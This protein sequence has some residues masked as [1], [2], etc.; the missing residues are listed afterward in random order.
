MGE[1]LDVKNVIVQRNGNAILNDVT[2]RVN[3]GERWVILGANGAGKT[4]LISIA[5]GRMQPTSGDVAIVGERLDSADMAEMK[6]LVGVASSAVD[7]KISARETVLDVVRT[8]AYGKITAW[9]ER[10]EDEDTERALGLLATLVL[11]TRQIVRLVLFLLVN[12]S[13]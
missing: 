4:T 13:G 11:L 7:A 6:A 10:Y 2:W 5:S 9:N 12:V 8:A 1:V 3:D